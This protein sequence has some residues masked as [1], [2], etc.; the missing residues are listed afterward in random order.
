MDIVF[1]WSSTLYNIY[2][3]RKKNSLPYSSF[4]KELPY[5][6]IIKL[7]GLIFY[8]IQIISHKKIQIIFIIEIHQN[9]QL[10][11]LHNIFPKKKI[12]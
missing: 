1:F 2:I 10:L 4:L 8:I 11:K 6:Y 5:S 9:K 3:R 12:T 7:V